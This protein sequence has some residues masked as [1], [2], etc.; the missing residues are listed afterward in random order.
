MRVTAIT[1]GA[2]GIGAAAA[3][4]LCARGD[5]VLIADRDAEAARRLAD[6]VGGVAVEVDV[7]REGAGQTVIDAALDAW[8]RLDAVVAS[9][10]IERGGPAEDIPRDVLEQ[11]YSVNVFGSFD[12]AQAAF[13]T[14]RDQGSG[15]RIVLIGSANSMVALPGQ[16]AYASSKGAVLMMARS[17]AVDW[18][19][20]GVTVNVVGP[21]VTDT[22]MSAQSLNDPA[23]RAALM[24]RIPMGRPARPEDIA[25]A[26]EFLSSER[27]G[28]ITG[29]YLPV[30]GG[31]LAAG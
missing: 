5:R 17:L 20:E 6:E 7:T 19:S 24:S 4:R 3:R 16:S 30:D 27:V 15:G 1:G 29:A 2:A 22:A 10:G 26:I 14:F 9:A 13:R 21:G 8:G 31:W 11:V 28:Y 12:V 18:A 25:E 23:R